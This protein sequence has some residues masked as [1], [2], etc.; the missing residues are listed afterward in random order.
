VRI[1]DVRTRDALSDGLRR[2][3]AQLAEDVPDEIDIEAWKRAELVV[4]VVQDSDG[5]EGLR[6]IVA[7]RSNAVAVG[8]EVACLGWAAALAK[9]GTT[10]PRELEVEAAGALIPSRTAEGPPEGV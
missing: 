6:L 9:S 8:D 10:D 2:D 4:Y 7:P 1:V 3:L 5:P